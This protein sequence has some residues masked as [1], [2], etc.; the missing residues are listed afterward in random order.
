[1]LRGRSRR[2]APRCELCLDRSELQARAVAGR[3][4]TEAERPAGRRRPNPWAAVA[5]SSSRIEPSMAD[6][7]V[8]KFLNACLYLLVG[9]VVRTKRFIRSKTR[10]VGKGRGERCRAGVAA[11]WVR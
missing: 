6:A 9:Y 5:L 4:S 11:G 10:R 3:C 2:P 7:I 8:G 1:M